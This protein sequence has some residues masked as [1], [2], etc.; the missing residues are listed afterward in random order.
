MILQ[1]IHSS[2]KNSLLLLQKCQNCVLSFEYA[3]FIQI[4]SQPKQKINF[5]VCM[6]TFFINIK[7][8]SLYF[9]YGSYSTQNFAHCMDSVT[10]I[11]EKHLV[12]PSLPLYRRFSVLK[13]SEQ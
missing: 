1:V 13:F 6:L 5:F 9:G 12:V 8:Q 4:L 11:I 2:V 7:R 10:R 3:D